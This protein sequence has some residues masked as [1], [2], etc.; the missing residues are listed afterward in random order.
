MR[1]TKLL[2]RLQYLQAR[3]LNTNFHDFFEGLRAQSRKVVM[4]HCHWH[5]C[6]VRINSVTT[7]HTR[8]VVEVDSNT[9]RVTK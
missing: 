8:R 4:H 6:S 1:G 3:G 5:A 9:S 2:P 7:E